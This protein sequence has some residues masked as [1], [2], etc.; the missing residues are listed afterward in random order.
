MDEDDAAN[1][2]KIEDSFWYY[3]LEKYTD[4]SKNIHGLKA[5]LFNRGILS[6]KKPESSPSIVTK[7]IDIKNKKLNV[8]I[9]ELNP[10]D[11]PYLYYNIAYRAQ[12][13][14]ETLYMSFM[15]SSV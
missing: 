2:I 5:V 4:D 15:P 9:K 6:T 1:P 14:E 7:S 3:W 13:S 12:D 11:Q 8:E 10:E